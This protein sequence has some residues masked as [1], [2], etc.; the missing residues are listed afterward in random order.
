M[1]GEETTAD[2]EEG[3]DNID[4]VVR[5]PQAIRRGTAYGSTTNGISVT[6]CCT[7]TARYHCQTHGRVSQTPCEEFSIITS[8]FF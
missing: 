7:R 5:S 8:G 1:E 3:I 2:T 4:N 6:N